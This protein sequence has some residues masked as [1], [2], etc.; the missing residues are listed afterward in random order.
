MAS[1]PA[2]IATKTLK[3][4][5]KSLGGVLE[6]VRSSWCSFFVLCE[7]IGDRLVTLLG[8]KALDLE[9]SPCGEA[10]RGIKFA[11]CLVHV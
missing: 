5:F 1:L 8:E 2:S 7:G 10:F 9:S 11:S 6:L 4:I 3:S